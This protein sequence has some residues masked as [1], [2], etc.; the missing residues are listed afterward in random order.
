[1]YISFL[2]TIVMA[3]SIDYLFNEKSPWC[4]LP[5]SFTDHHIQ[6]MDKK[7]PTPEEIENARKILKQ[8]DGEKNNSSSSSLYAGSQVP[9][10][11][12]TSTSTSS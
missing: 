12:Y 9:N 7:E 10:L 11:A 8:V 5:E 2:A 6:L 4:I 1:M 3:F